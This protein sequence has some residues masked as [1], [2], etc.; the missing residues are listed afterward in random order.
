MEFF[1]PIFVDHHITG[2]RLL[3]MNEARLAQLGINSVGA[4]E[5]LMTEIAILRKWGVSKHVHWYVTDDDHQPGNIIEGLIDGI[6]ELIRGI[7][8]GLVGVLYEPAKAVRQDGSGGFYGGLG[9]GLT[10]LVFRPL[11]GACDFLR[12]VS[13]GI[14]NTP[15]CLD[16][17]DEK[18]EYLKEKVDR[19]VQEKR[20]RR[21][22]GKKERRPNTIDDDY[23]RNVFRGIQQ[24]IGRFVIQWYL[25]F[26]VFMVRTQPA[27]ACCSLGTAAGAADDRQRTCAI[28][29]TLVD[30][31]MLQTAPCKSESVPKGVFKGVMS[32]VCRPTAGCIDLVQRIAEGVVNTPDAMF[33]AC[34][35]KDFRNRE[36]IV[37]SDLWWERNADPGGAAVRPQM[38][39]S[40][41]SNC[42]CRSLTRVSLWLCAGD[43]T[44]R[45]GRRIKRGL[46]G[47]VQKYQ[48]GHRA[49]GDEHD[50][51]PGGKRWR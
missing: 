48:R 47:R 42:A 45:T 37:G 44:G 32:L 16:S 35:V 27:T 17:E 6:T 22:A 7:M 9:L 25:G 10:G 8:E 41:C 15:M 39:L 51:G 34:Q 2:L 26:H 4:R 20:D 23:P 21:E 46:H 29:L 19:E 28:M 43:G 33:D 14:K 3:K 30:C 18:E 5:H 24:G 40:T 36:A 13:D 12:N 50:A 1:A 49:S 38:P 11:G 31:V